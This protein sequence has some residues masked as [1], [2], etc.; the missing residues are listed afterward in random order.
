[1]HDMPS[2]SQIAHLI[3]ISEAEVSRY[4]GDTFRLGDT[5]LIHFAFVM[6]SELRQRLTGSFTFTLKIP[7]TLSDVHRV[8]FV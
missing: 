2:D 1:M 8:D 3:G 4:R 6:P 7:P 5:W